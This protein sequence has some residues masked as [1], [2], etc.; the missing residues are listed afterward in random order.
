[1]DKPRLDID[2]RVNITMALSRYLRTQEEFRE[3]SIAFNAASADVKAV[4]PK[5]LRFITSIHGIYYVIDTY[6]NGDFEIDEIE[7]V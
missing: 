1:M 3:A 5:G 7:N 2:T 6:E 4:L